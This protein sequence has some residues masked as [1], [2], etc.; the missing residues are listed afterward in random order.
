MRCF[1]HKGPAEAYVSTRSIFFRIAGLAQ[2][3]LRCEVTDQLP[4]TKVRPRLLSVRIAIHTVCKCGFWICKE[5]DLFSFNSGTLPTP[6]F[7]D[8]GLTSLL[9]ETL[10]WE[11]SARVRNPFT[12]SVWAFPLTK[13]LEEVLRASQRRSLPRISQSISLCRHRWKA[14]CGRSASDLLG[15]ISFR[16]GGK[17]RTRANADYTGA[18]GHGRGVGSSLCPIPNWFPNWSLT[19]GRKLIT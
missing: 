8:L 10:K 3:T 17:A 5:Q 13:P 18:H 16:S 19:S 11:G 7:S 1:H 2:L 14:Q 12:G 6:L 4:D 9:G 15:L